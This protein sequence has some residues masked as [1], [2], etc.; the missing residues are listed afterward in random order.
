MSAFFCNYGVIDDV[1]DLTFETLQEADERIESKTFLGIWLLMMN[2]EAVSQRYNLAGTD[3]GKENMIISAEYEHQPG[4]QSMEQQLRSLG[5]LTYQMSEGS[6]PDY[7]LF[8]KLVT[9]EEAVCLTMTGAGTWNR[10]R[11]HATASA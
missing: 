1:V 10:T 8:K 3:E 4:G 7:D 2:A 9:I 11:D 6:V 5:C